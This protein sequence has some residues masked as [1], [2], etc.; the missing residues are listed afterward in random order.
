MKETRKKVGRYHLGIRDVDLYWRRGTG[1]DFDCAAK[2]GGLAELVVGIDAEHWDEVVAALLHEAE[3][4]TLTDLCCR[5][6]PTPDYGASQGGYLFVLDH[7]QFC[8]AMGRVAVLVAG[9]LPALAAAY[10]KNRKQRPRQ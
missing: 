4:M 5:F 7:E 3:E 10:K 9:A 6:R 2:P 1:G 8:E